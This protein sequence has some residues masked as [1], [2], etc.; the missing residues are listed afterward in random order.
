VVGEYFAE[1][2]TEPIYMIRR[3]GKKLIYSANDP[4]QY[5]DLI[6]DPLETYNLAQNVE[7][8]AEVTTLIDE[9][10]KRYDHD[11]L[12]EGVLESQ[13]RRRFLKNV[14]CEQ[15]VCWDYQH[16]EDAGNV[17]I[18]NTMPIYQLEKKA[19]FPQV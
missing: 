6:Q 10:D 15:S 19:R 16:V 11:A 7:F 1:G 5:F 9:I 4:T 14:M 17:Y 3:G 13:R 2:T 8:Q 12:I 18:R